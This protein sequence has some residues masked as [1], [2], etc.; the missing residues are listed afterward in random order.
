MSKRKRKKKRTVVSTE[1]PQPLVEPEEPVTPIEEPVTEPLPKP[2]N[3]VRELK[4]K[5]R[6]IIKERPSLFYPEE[7]KLQPWVK[8]LEAAVK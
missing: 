5:L 2:K 3:E 8:K 1:F 6:A 4:K 7:Q